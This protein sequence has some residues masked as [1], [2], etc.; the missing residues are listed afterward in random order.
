VEDIEALIDEA[1]GGG[2]LCGISSGAALALDAAQRGLGV[3][4]L[5]LHEPPFIV[6]DSR[7]RLPHDYPTRVKELLDSNRRGDAVGLFMRQVGLPRILIALMRF[8]PAM[9]KATAIA[10]TLPYDAAM[11][12]DTQNGKPLPADRWDAVK[13]PAL[14]V[15]GGKS[16][17]WMHNGTRALANML[18]AARYHVLDGGTH[19]VEPKALAP[20]LADFFSEGRTTVE[21]FAELSGRSLRR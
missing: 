2:H 16:P 6:D 9:R 7:P 14:V 21:D 17:A 20:V 4:S 1:G 3:R 5:A 18:P 19:M 10:H 11:M 15:V 13:V 8:M 12:G